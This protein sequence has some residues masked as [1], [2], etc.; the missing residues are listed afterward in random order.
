MPL[1]WM[2]YRSN[3][4]PAG[5]VIKDAA[6]LGD[7]RMLAKR[8]GFETGVIF[9]EGHMLDAEL[10]TMVS[11]GEIGRFLPL[12]EANSIIKRFEAA[13]GAKPAARAHNEVAPVHPGQSPARTAPSSR[14][15]AKWFFERTATGY[16]VCDADRRE[17]L[18]VVVNFATPKMLGYR[19]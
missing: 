9:A 4:R 6:N 7:A 10:S 14:A 18:R 19:K 3:D 16:V 5:V 17:A 11:P 2:F 12:P 13:A 8:D 1:F 15:P